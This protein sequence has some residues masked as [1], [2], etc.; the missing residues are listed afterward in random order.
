M[1]PDTGD[2]QIS[3]VLARDLLADVDKVARQN[4]RSR[5]GEIR[6]A[7]QRHVVAEASEALKALGERDRA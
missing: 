4:N 1:E 6:A 3:L 2:T 7:L 5:A